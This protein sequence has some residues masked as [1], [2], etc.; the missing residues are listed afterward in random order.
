MKLCLINIPYL[1]VYGKINMGHNSAYPLGLGYIAAVAKER[2]HEVLLLDPEAEGKDLVSVVDRLRD[3]RPDL[4][5]LSCVTANFTIACR[6]ASVIKKELP[7]LLAVGGVHV[8]A[9]PEKSLQDC[10]DIDIVVIGEGEYV[11]SALCDF[12]EKK[13]LDLA[14]VPSIAYRKHGKVVINEK[15]GFI[16]DLDR[17]PYP[18]RTQVDVGWY[19]LQPQFER[20]KLH[21][22]ILSSR[23]CPSS[24]TFCGNITTGRKYRPHGAV[25][26]VNEL[27]YLVKKY[28][29]R[30]FH[31]V[32]DNFAADRD[33]VVRI[34][35][36]ILRR[37]LNITWF[38]FGRVDQLNDR[39]LLGL[40]K[41]AGCIYIL[42]GVE[43]GNQRILDNI[44]KQV[45]LEQ[46]EAACR[47][48]REAGIRYLNSFIIGCPGETKKTAEDT[49]RFA[50]SLK[51][52]ITGFSIL[53]PFPGTAIFQQYYREKVKE[54]KD[55]SNWCSVGDD[56][57][58]D[59]TH[60]E[61]SREELLK[62]VAGAYRRYYLRLPQIIRLLSFGFRPSVLLAYLRGG[63]GLL[64]AS[65]NWY[66][67]SKTAKKTP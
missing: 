55:W 45:T 10:P 40:M 32:D 9:L 5:G 52:V 26:F 35:E 62:I 7:V 20:G 22:T 31:I 60:T 66:F 19:R 42:F 49:V 33:R 65:F 59:Y 21:A 67:A 6:W 50:I 8:S 14:A 29:I 58:F 53:I 46:T 24:C 27:E 2:G 39:E 56:I 41:K 51:A 43:S 25:Y 47:L 12:I 16:E 54:I 61:L 37:Q 57:P 30:H 1:E 48:C 3:F 23:G 34:C 63:I 44:K 36:E 13:E 4:V 18:D 28:G 15:K 17:L 64:R 38:I 11:V